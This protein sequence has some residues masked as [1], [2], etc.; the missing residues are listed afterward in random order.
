MGHEIP[1]PING[2]K[3]T[4]K[5]Y[6]KIGTSLSG[7]EKLLEKVSSLDRKEAERILAL[8]SAEFAASIGLDDKSEDESEDDDEAPI[9]LTEE[10]DDKS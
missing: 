4:K 1:E 5:D 8:G 2:G 10:C 9:V 3:N 6:A 7:S